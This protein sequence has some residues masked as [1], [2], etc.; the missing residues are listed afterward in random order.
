M[1]EKLIDAAWKKFVRY[2]RTLS[3]VD[4]HFYLDAREAAEVALSTVPP[5][6]MSYYQPL[7]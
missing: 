2:E 5:S 3:D 6:R 7:P 4:Y 1:I